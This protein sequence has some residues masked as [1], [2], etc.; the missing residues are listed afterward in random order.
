VSFVAETPSISPRCVCDTRL[1]ANLALSPWR[2]RFRVRPPG[3]STFGLVR[4]GGKWKLLSVGLIL[5]I[6][7]RWRSNGKT[8]DLEA[9]RDDAIA[10][11]PSL[12]CA[13]EHT[14][15]PTE[16]LP[17]RAD[18]LG[19]A[20]RVD[21]ARGGQ[22]GR[23]GPICGK[24]KADMRSVQNRASRRQPVRGEAN[25]AAKFE[26]AAT[27]VEYARRPAVFYSDS[28]GI[29]RGTDKR[30]LSRLSADPRMILR[31]AFQAPLRG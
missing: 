22:P 19:P 26:L 6:F 17:G 25:Q 13:G 23:R 18:T 5:L 2:S 24:Q 16:K 12:H 3:R 14:G 28:G 9:R 21:I 10:A 29:L 30:V 20:H 7:L 11:L 31:R 15:G 8:A 4:E 1:R 27:P